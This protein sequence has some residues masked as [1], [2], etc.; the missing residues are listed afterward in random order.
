MGAAAYSPSSLSYRYMLT[1]AS[2]APPLV[3]MGVHPPAGMYATT[4][5]WGA[6]PAQQPLN[7]WAPRGKACN[8]RV[9][10]GVGGVRT[11]TAFGGRG[12][13]GGCSLPTSPATPSDASSAGAMTERADYSSRLQAQQ[14]AI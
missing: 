2:P 3:G 13:G 4:S 7:V 10:A 14:A 1:A 9:P 11:R 8:G 12:G 6:S 5:G